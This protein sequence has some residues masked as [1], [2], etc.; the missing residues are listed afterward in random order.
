M[1]RPHSIL[2]QLA[3]VLTSKLYWPMASRHSTPGGRY[4]LLVTTIACY[5]KTMRGLTIG[6]YSLLVSTYMPMGKMPFWDPRSSV[7]SQIWV[8]RTPRTRYRPLGTPDFAF[9][10]VLSREPRFSENHFENQGGFDKFT[11]FFQDRRIN[12]Q[13]HFL[14]ARN[15]QIWEI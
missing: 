11:P 10:G 9:F 2:Q 12:A 1:V 14:G 15:T 4:R 3:V 13:N 5:G 7:F 8:F 6:Q